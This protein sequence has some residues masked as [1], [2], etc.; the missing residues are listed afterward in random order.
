MLRVGAVLA[1]GAAVAA[2]FVG[3]RVPQAKASALVGWR[4]GGEGQSAR[5]TVSPLV[6]INPRL[7]QQSRQELFTV[8]SSERSYWRLTALDQ[9]DCEVWSSN[10]EYLKASGQLPEPD[11]LP[12]TS[13]NINQHYKVDSLSTIWL[14]AA[15]RPVSIAAGDTRARYEESSGTLIVGNDVGSSDGLTY[16]VGSSVPLYD[17]ATLAS[18]NGPIPDDIVNRDMGV[19]DCLTNRIRRLAQEVTATGRTSY[20]K[21]LALQNYFRDSFTYDLTVPAG[22]AVNAMETF[23]FETRRGYCEQFAG[24]FA[25]MARAIGLPTRVAVGFTPGEQDE[26][27]PNL[28]HVLGLHAHAWP[29]VY[30]PGQGWVLFEPTPSRGAPNAEPYTH[31]AE[32]QASPVG[33]ATTPPASTT[34]STGP[35]GTSITLPGNGFNQP[36][37]VATGT[38][39]SSTAEPSFWSPERVGGQSIVASGLLIALAIVYAIAVPTI[40][41]L[42]RRRRRKRAVAPE[43]QVR[44][45]WQ[46][47]V[48]LVGVLGVAPARSETPAEFAHRL[49][50]TVDSDAYAALAATL[51]AAEFSAEGVTPEEAAAALAI[52]EELAASIRRRASGEQRIRAVLDPRPPERRRPATRRR[53]AKRARR[54]APEIELLTRE[55]NLLG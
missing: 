21:A 52:S 17:P 55:G 4:G 9:F 47:S 10:G 33:P 22:Q 44:L 46:E 37:E 13:A 23:L 24:T 27:N 35:T 41:L 40:W 14:P 6:E 28:Y 16:D 11:A 26:A 3:P 36:A 1:I 2:A 25:A 31:V 43:D 42:Y 53:T 49:E 5:T 38:G 34:S 18:A 45:A 15:F 30:F 29:E 8:E 54:D 48:E 51:D 12:A 39:L 19:P 20:D 7:V 50:N 32:Q